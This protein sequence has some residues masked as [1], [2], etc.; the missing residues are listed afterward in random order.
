MI[1][2]QSLPFLVLFVA[3][4][5]D[6]G[7]CEDYVPTPPVA[8]S[9]D[10]GCLFQVKD[11]YER[12]TPTFGLHLWGDDTQ[13][14]IAHGYLLSTQ[15]IDWLEFYLIR[16]VFKG[17][18]TAYNRFY[19][20][21]QVNITFPEPFATE[22]DAIIQ[23]MTNSKKPMT[24]PSLNRTITKYDI[25]VMNSY[26][27]V[28]AQLPGPWLVAPEYGYSTSCTQF[29]A[30]YNFTD[31]RHLLTGRN[32]DGFW[33]ET[34]VT[35][36]HLIIFAIETPNTPRIISFLWPGFVGSLSAI[37]ENGVY[38]MMNTG[39]MNAVPVIGDITPISVIQRSII[40]NV[41]NTNFSSS[42]IQEYVI[43]NF[44]SKE[45][46][47]HKGACGGGAIL[48]CACDQASDNYNKS[49]T[50]FI[51]EMD[52]INTV[53]RKPRDSPDLLIKDAIMTSNHFR[54]YG[55]NVSEE[56]SVFNMDV[57]TE[58]YNSSWRYETGREKLYAYNRTVGYIDVNAMQDILRS[59]SHG[60]NLLSIITQTTG[61]I[62]FWF[63]VADANSDF[64]DAPY[65]QWYHFVFESLFTEWNVTNK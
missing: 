28:T 48:V 9:T 5:F 10:G 41:L 57:R 6:A 62:Q 47:T 46:S 52:R 45:S 60:V 24:I 40:N 27:E 16:T 30:T 8:E 11:S 18:N 22:I 26:L 51:L 23:G 63:S 1:A 44:A 12:Q 42:L 29:V 55:V 2:A 32:M 37:N 64:W 54:K 65:Q 21:V 33:D 19:K 43:N 14:G 34:K 13:R 35:V 59:V 49:E 20:F 50:M 3:I 38:V 58:Y 56:F 7:I 4:Q 39:N 15:I 53:V 36:T 17:S 25:M 61:S 31:N